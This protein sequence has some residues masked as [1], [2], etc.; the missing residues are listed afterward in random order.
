M[1]Y[2]GICLDCA[3]TFEYY[4]RIAERESVPCCLAC[5][6]ANTRKIIAA[7]PI[8]CVKGKF[9]PFKSQ[10]DG[11]IITNNR[12]LAEHNKRNNVCLLGEGY[13][14]E[15][16]LAGRCGKTEM[17]KPDKKDIAKDIVEAIKRCESGYKPKIESEGAEL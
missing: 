4:R 1:K 2:D 3:N 16:I 12:E 5:G 7:A 6:S 13:S 14:N 10:L 11:S 17:D 9:E 8:G 15:D